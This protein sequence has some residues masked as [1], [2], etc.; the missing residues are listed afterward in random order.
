MNNKIIN[1]NAL[2]KV[3]LFNNNYIMQ[4]GPLHKGS[5]RQ[6]YCDNNN[7]LFNKNVAVEV[8]KIKKYYTNFTIKI[9]TMSK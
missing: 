4:S 5:D 8:L 7:G 2:Q 3:Y 1:S 9:V 6:I